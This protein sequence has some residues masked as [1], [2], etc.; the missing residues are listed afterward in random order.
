M[1]SKYKLSTETK[2]IQDKVLHRIIALRDFSDVKSGELGGWVETRGNLS[3]HG[4]CWVYDDAWVLDNARILG[5][6]IVKDNAEV[7]GNAVITGNAIIK[8]DSLIEGDVT[9][10]GDVVTSC[11][12]WIHGVSQLKGNHQIGLD[13]NIEHEND[14]FSISPIGVLND[15][16]TFYKTDDSTYV[17]FRLGQ[18]NNDIQKFEKIFELTEEYSL[19]IKL[20]KL[21]VEG[22]R[23]NGNV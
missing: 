6:A 9:I 16:I 7:S 2:K 8:G 4:D 18:F 19:A 21:K 10:T 22:G 13:A 11:N 14:V 20:G 17:N 1:P 12:A 15:T 3:G 5:S 23:N